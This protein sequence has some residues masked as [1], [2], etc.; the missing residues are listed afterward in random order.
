MDIRAGKSSLG[1]FITL[2]S[3]AGVLTL[4]ALAASL[5]LTL[6]VFASPFDERQ[7]A[8]A[9]LTDIQHQALE[10]AY[11]VLDGTLSDGESRPATCNRD[12]VAVR[13]EL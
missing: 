6:G 11:K 8:T 10:N 2:H 7:A 5:C 1:C 4:K 3:M 12:T 9:R 13:K